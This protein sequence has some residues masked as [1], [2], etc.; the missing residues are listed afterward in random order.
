MMDNVDKGLRRMIKLIL[1]IL[2]LCTM[3][4]YADDKS[5]TI[6]FGQNLAKPASEHTDRLYLKIN[7]SEKLYFNHNYSGPAARGLD[8]NLRHTVRVFF[9]DQLSESWTID[10]KKLKATSVL[11]WRSPG[12][13]RMQAIKADE[14]KDLTP[15]D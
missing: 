3:S 1:L 2:F 15:M 13:W 6:C 4:A 14:C 11:I 10:F 5:G 12:A 7:D 8:T 9:D